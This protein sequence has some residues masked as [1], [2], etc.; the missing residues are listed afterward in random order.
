MRQIGAIPEAHESQASLT[1][2]KKSQ[3]GTAG[4]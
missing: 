1:A 2:S 4:N 3:T